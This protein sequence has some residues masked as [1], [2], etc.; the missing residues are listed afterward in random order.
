MLGGF[1]MVF[2][3]SMVVTWPCSS[4][5][6]YYVVENAIN[7]KHKSLLRGSVEKRMNFVALK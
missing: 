6:F 1:F 7:E 3:R 2:R 4:S 5:F